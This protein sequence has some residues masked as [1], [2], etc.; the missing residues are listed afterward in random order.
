M[1]ACGFVYEMVAELISSGIN[2]ESPLPLVLLDS[3]P[4]AQL[5]K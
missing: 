5:I 4:E 2:T 1:D 3:Y